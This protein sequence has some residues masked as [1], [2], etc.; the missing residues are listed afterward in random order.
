MHLQQLSGMTLIE[1]GAIGV[2]NDANFIF[3]SFICF[4]I[5]LVSQLKFNYQ[6]LL[7][8]GFKTPRIPYKRLQKSPLQH[9]VKVA[10]WEKPLLR[11]PF[12]HHHPDR[13]LNL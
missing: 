3:L 13:V 10:S 11:K 5:H 9:G 4:E 1:E 8:L 12:D 7:I 2:K 6:Q